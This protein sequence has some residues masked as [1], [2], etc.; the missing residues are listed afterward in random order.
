MSE[1]SSRP[2]ERTSSPTCTSATGSRHSCAAAPV[3]FPAS[4]VGSPWPPAP[5]DR[6]AILMSEMTTAPRRRSATGSG[7]G[8][9]RITPTPSRPCAPRSPAATSTRSTLSSTS[10]RRSSGRPAA[11]AARLANL[12]QPSRWPFGDGDWRLL[13][14]DGWAIV[15]AS[16]ELF[17]ARR[18]GRVWTRPIKG[19]RPRGGR[20][21]LLASA[22]DAAEH[23]M[24]VDLERNDLSRVCVP[25]SV[26]WPELMVAEPLAGV[27][28]LVSTVE[29]V[30]R[31]EVG[32]A[33]LL[34]AMFPGGSVTGAPKIAAVDLIAELEPVGRGA[35]MGALGP[36]PRERRPRARA[37][38]PDVRDRRPSPTP[39][40]RRRDRLGLGPRGGG[41]RD[42][43]EGG[44]AAG[45]DRGA[46]RG[47]SPGRA[48]GAPLGAA[49]NGA[50]PRRRRLGARR[51]RSLARRHRG[52]RRGIRPRPRGLRDPP[53]LRRQAVPTRGAPAAAGD[54]REPARTRAAERG[55]APRARGRGRRRGRRAGC[56]APA[57]L[58]SR[59]GRRRTRDRPRLGDSGLDRACTRTGAAGGLARVPPPIAAHGFCRARS[60]SATR[61]TSRQS[62]RRSVEAPTTPCS[63]TSTRSSSRGR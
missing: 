33:E 24:I 5:S 56:G 42:A 50:S 61:P 18:G 30:L 26:H 16:P 8:P 53:R 25:G 37:D 27:E 54:V 29:G 15:S 10:R 63:S 47:R 35:S 31:P 11:L 60:R 22:K 23:V 19:T 49:R 13:E 46:A 28:H 34:G 39:L 7:R 6:H 14:G 41:R 57:V 32:L 51:R 12:T 55:R 3:R 4:P 62:S 38:D 43:H 45:R 36:R 48:A 40:G 52:G 58:D 2:A 21:E 59:R 20:A 9:R 17:L 44:A 1:G